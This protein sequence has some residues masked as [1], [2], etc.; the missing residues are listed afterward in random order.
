MATAT[1]AH[2]SSR[3]SFLFAAVGS[4]VGLGNIWKFPYMTGANGGAAFVLVYLAASVLI[5]TP[6]LMSEVLVGR[7]AQLSPVGSMQLVAKESGASGRWSFFGYLGLAGAFLI[8]SFYAVIAG[9]S[10][11]YLP[12]AASGS[13]R[14]LDADA[15]QSVFGE[16]LSAPIEMALWQALFIAV[17]GFIVMRGVNRGIERT[18]QVL[19]PML[20]V[21]LMVFIVYSAWAGDFGAAAQFLLAPD[22]SKLTPV[23]VMAAVGQALFSLSVG[24][25][26]MMTYGAYL[27]PEVNIPRSSVTIAAID[28]A[29]ALAAGF[30]IFPIVFANGLDPS[31]GPGLIFVSLSL[32]FAHMPAGTLLGTLFFLLLIGAAL[33]TSISFI[34]PIVAWADE[35]LGVARSKSVVIACVSVWLVGLI[36]VL[37]FN[38]WS[39]LY[40]LGQFETF[41][42]K[43]PFDLIDYLITNIM[44]PA[45]ALLLVIFVGWKMNDQLRREELG[46]AD[47]QRGF[48]DWWLFAVKYLAPIVIVTLFL[49][50]IA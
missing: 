6:V 1:H 16:L 27:P 23:S 26:A 36:T 13:L 2:W 5:A 12:K 34:E 15:I 43:T 18:L 32:S 19:M 40:L 42:G 48:Y 41:A 4:A 20:F 22:F 44:Q 37:S 7:H 31:E 29:V 24:F 49:M 50:G 9:W 17:T 25:G 8:M 30:A 28:T 11:A 38:V 46:A 45:G 39:E 35:N 10:L 33:T 47:K 3:T 14:G 21:M